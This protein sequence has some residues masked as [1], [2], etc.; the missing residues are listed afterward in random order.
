MKIPIEIINHIL[1][2]RPCHP[3]AILIKERIKDYYGE[4]LHCFGQYNGGVSQLFIHEFISFK[5]WVFF[6]M[7][8]NGPWR[9]KN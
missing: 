1:L 6:Y 2:Y 9:L 3:V 5:E 4:C 7:S 8:S